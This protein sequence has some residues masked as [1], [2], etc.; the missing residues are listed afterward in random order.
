MAE[1]REWLVTNGLGG[2][3]SGTVAGLLTRRYHGLLIAATDPPVGR[4]LLVPKIDER[5]SYLGAE[6]ALATNRWAD[7][8]IDP[9]G[10]RHIETFSIEDGMPIWQFAIADALLEKRIWMP[11]GENATCIRFDLVRASAPLRLSLTLFIDGRDHHGTTN[12]GAD[13][14]APAIERDGLC[15]RAWTGAPEL[16]VT[17]ERMDWALEGAWYYGFDLARERERGL[18][19]REDHWCVGRG[20]VE[21]QPGASCSLMLRNG[22]P[23]NVAD[24]RNGEAAAR[25]GANLAAWRRSA[26]R[27]AQSAPKWIEDLV[28][29]AD[30]F[31]VARGQGHTIV[32]GYPWFTDWGRDTMISLPG[33]AL[34]TGRNEIARSI[35]D[36]FASHVDRGM[37]PNRFTDDGAAEYNTIDA[38]LWFV[39]AIDRYLAATGDERFAKQFMPVVA[40]II[41]CHVRGTRHGIA[42]DP[43]DGL[44]GGGEAGVQLTWMDAKVGDRVVTPRV[45][46]PIEVNALWLNAIAT[47][48]RLAR[49]TGAG[50]QTYDELLAQARVGFVRFWNATAGQCY[51]V[52]DGPEGNDAAC[53]PNQL[54]AVSLPESA[55]DIAQQRAVVDTCARSFLTSYGLRSLAADDPAY[56]GHY[57]GDPAA[58]DGAYHQGT[59]WAWLLGP[60]ALA[61]YRA[62]GDARA[63]LR[64]LDPLADAIDGYGVGTLG[65]VFDGEP[66]HAPRGC[67]AQAWSV[68]QVLE[69]W[70]M[71]TAHTRA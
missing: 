49:N 29:A 16:R 18:E 48:A 57:T 42:R 9:T 34:A 21:L 33:L 15:C 12:A 23:P 62:Y 39:L 69:A 65:E 5:A 14:P 2:Y 3:A 17:C 61:H 38:T 58:R 7:G 22:G 27:A 71:L 66:P 32:A 55:L 52:L 53:R 67:I 70:T 30:Q 19:S 46:K 36:T 24:A 45:G 35:L 28:L 43:T 44:L 11:H 64:Y 37:I 13:P 40:D 60:F 4:S 31:V 56:V 59:V 68:A 51:D 47:A 63:S 1:R 8:T 20:T 10:H 54:F 50:T 6:Y 41:D 25:A 26:G